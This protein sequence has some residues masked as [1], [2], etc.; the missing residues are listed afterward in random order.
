MRAG[1]EV[2]E[3]RSVVGPGGATAWQRDRRFFSGMAIAAAVTVFSGFAPTYFLK[4]LFGMPPLPPFLH[5]HGLLF[6]SWILLFLVQARLIAVKRT[7][8][9]RRIGAAG[10]LLAVG[11]VGVGLAAAIASARRGFTPPG[12]P[13][14]LVFFAIPLGDLVVFSTLV[15]VGLYLRRRTET[16]KRLMLLATIGLLTPAIARLPYVAAWGPPAFFGLTDLFIV[17]CLLYDRITRGRV[18]PGFF[19]GGL[20]IL[21]SQPLRLLIAGT[22]PWLAFAGWLTS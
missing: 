9:H 2:L 20:F 18:H 14:P 5:V 16:H 15:G 1:V 17:T 11:M 21:V 12:G 4:G 10:G 6:T 3:G 13:P 22:E 8:L 7:D 19:W